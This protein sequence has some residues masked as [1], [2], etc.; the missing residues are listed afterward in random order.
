[1]PLLE[2]LHRSLA[3]DTD[4]GGRRQREVILIC[5]RSVYYLS[6]RCYLRGVLVV[7]FSNGKAPC[8]WASQRVVS[9][10]QC[11]PVSCPQLRTGQ[12]PV[13]WV[14]SGHAGNRDRGIARSVHTRCYCE[15]DK[16]KYS[17]PLV[18]PHLWKMGHYWLQPDSHRKSKSSTN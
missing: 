17:L 6:K 5:T 4:P 11:G 8:S 3:I 15:K 16:K 7:A 2:V 14:P 12:L 18:C 9:P 1:M 13:Q 10:G